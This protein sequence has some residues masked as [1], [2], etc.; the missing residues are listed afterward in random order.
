TF[1]ILSKDTKNLGHDKALAW[2][3]RG[4]VSF[5][6][7]KQKKRSRLLLLTRPLLSSYTANQTFRQPISAT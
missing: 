2:E 7:I 3:S 1:E 4:F 6:T 5:K